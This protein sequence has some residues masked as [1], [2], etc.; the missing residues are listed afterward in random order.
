[1][2]APSEIT[3]E[4]RSRSNG[5]LAVSGSSFLHEASPL[6]M[7]LAMVNGVIGASAPPAMAMSASPDQIIAAA[8]AIAS[9]PEGQADETVAA[10]ADAPNRSAMKLTAACGIDAA[11][12]VGAARFG[13]ISLTA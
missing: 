3:P 11:A 6:A 2:H 13:P 1:M 5:R 12:E 4:S 9:K 8:S 7:K 10:R